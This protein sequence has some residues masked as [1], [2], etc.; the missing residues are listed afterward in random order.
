MY[1]H[2]SNDYQLSNQKSV[3]QNEKQSFFQKL[4]VV[5]HLNAE[6][7]F[8]QCQ[9]IVKKINHQSNV[10]IFS[11]T[12]NGIWVNQKH[13]KIIFKV[14]HGLVNLAKCLLNAMVQENL[15]KIYYPLHNSTD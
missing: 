3:S 13:L 11:I 15:Q 6:F 10:K 14:C 5:S 7:I 8:A 4:I 2:L 12:A 9:S 1:S